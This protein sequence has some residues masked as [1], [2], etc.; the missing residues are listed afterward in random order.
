MI[1]KTAANLSINCRLTITF[2]LLQPNPHIDFPLLITFLSFRSV[3][4]GFHIGTARRIPQRI[5][6]FAFTGVYHCMWLVGKTADVPLFQLCVFPRFSGICNLCLLPD[7]G[8]AGA[9]NL[10]IQS[11]V[12][13][14]RQYAD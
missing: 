9:V 11:N 12:F 6:V 14:F 10:C 1:K 2:A 3:V 7:A 13:S 8:A 4:F 5:A